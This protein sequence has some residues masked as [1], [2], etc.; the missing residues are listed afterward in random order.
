MANNN[1]KNLLATVPSQ[2]D[3]QSIV[4]AIKVQALPPTAGVA[5]LTSSSVAGDSDKNVYD[6]TKGKGNK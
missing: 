6:Q 4:G 3:T 1:T 5:A 2:V